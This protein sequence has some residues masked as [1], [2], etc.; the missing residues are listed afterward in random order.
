M[1]L[2]ISFSKLFI[3]LSC[4]VFLLKK[5]FVEK[6]AGEGT[7][8]VRTIDGKAEVCLFCGFVGLAAFD[9]FGQIKGGF[10]EE[11]VF[12]GGQCPFCEAAIGF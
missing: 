9:P 5:F 8:T 12:L 3:G 6:G 4:D 1:N 7:V 2:C 11:A 10:P